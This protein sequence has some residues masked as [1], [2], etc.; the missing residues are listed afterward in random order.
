MS[1]HTA[2]SWRMYVQVCG[3]E[4]VR[5][6]SR[7]DTTTVYL[8]GPDKGHHGLFICSMISSLPVAIM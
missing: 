6:S 3:Q 8:L 1:V 4:F 7:L 2:D 5:F